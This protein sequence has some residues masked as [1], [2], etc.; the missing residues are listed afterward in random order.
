[1]KQYGNLKLGRLWNTGYLHHRT[2]VWLAD[3]LT[4]TSG[5]TGVAMGILGSRVGCSFRMG[6]E[7]PENTQ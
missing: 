5:K 2:G 3:L 4:V 6:V 7:C 1:M